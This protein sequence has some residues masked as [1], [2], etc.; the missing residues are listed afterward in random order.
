MLEHSASE[1]DEEGVRLRRECPLLVEGREE[2]LC[3]L[4]KLF[5]G[6]LARPECR[7]D[8]IDFGCN[9]GQNAAGG[10]LEGWLDLL[11]KCFNASRIE[12]GL[13]SGKFAEHEIEG[14]G[15]NRNEAASQMSEV[16]GDG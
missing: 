7:M 2:L 1:Q 13:G 10:D 6:K 11:E 12:V 3:I 9:G 15:V 14:I 5:D 16:G 8:C 4:D